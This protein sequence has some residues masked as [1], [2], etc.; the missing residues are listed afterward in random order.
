M[1]LTVGPLPPAVYWRRRAVVLGSLLAVIVLVTYSCGGSGGADPAARTAGATASP[2]PDTAAGTTAPPADAAR[3]TDEPAQSPAPSAPASPAAPDGQATGGPPDPGVCTDD[4]IR[5]TPV[6]ATGQLPAGAP[7]DISL[8]IKNISQR[9]CRRDVGAD[10]QELYLKEQ[11]GAEKIW[12]SDDCGGIR[13]TNVESFTPGFER[14][15]EV[16]WTGQASTNCKDRPVPEPGA[17][18]LF[19]RVGTKRSNP[20]TL[21]L[22]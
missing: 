19:G 8:K 3:Q 11:G 16:S 2:A 20:V 13:G 10:Q 6:P 4:E 7:L 15:Y 9:T 5:V 18:D 1:R 12:S 14:A 21:T 17:Y 22:T